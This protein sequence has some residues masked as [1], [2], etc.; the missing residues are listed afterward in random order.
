MK[1]NFKLKITKWVEGKFILDESEHD[2]Y[3]EACERSSKLYGL[4]KI[5]NELNQL[6][7]IEK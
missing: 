6:V 2:T 4:V 3:Y 5:Y 7:Y 1:K